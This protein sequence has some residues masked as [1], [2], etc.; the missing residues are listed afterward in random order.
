MVRAVTFSAQEKARGLSAYTTLLSNMPDLILASLFLNVLSLALP[1][2]LLQVYD[3][4]IPNKSEGT[5]QLLVL[6]V[7]TA[8]LFEA[9]LRLGRSTIT[10][11]VGAR[12]EHMAGCG[13]MA[14]MLGT[15]VGAFERD[16]SGAHLERFNALATVKDFYAGQAILTLLDLPFTAIYLF[17]VWFIA[18]ELVLIPGLLLGLFIL[19][20]LGVGRKLREALKRRMTADDRRFNFIIEVLS[21]I[22]TVKSMGMEAQ[23]LRRYERL[24]EGCAEGDYNVAQVSA[25]ALSL[26]SFFSQITTA[27]VAAYGSTLVLDHRLT[28]GGLAACT[29]L[30]GRSL[31]PVQKA[32]GIWTRFQ[33]IR[34]ARA[35]LNEIFKLPLEASAGLPKLPPIGGAVRMD[36][37]R[38]R[39]N[40][41]S[42][43]IMSGL[44]V[45]IAAGECIAIGGGNG[46]GKSTLLALMIGAVRPTEGRVLLDGY[47]LAEV[48]PASVKQQVAYLPQAGTLFQGSILENITMFRPELTELAYEAAGRLGLDDV[49]KTMALGYDTK[50][51]DGAFDA[52]PRGIKQRIA[53]ARA[54]VC[55]PRVVLFDEA[56]TGVDGVGDQYLKTCLEGLKG[57]CTMILVTHR[58]SLVKLADRVFDFKDGV[59][60]ERKQVTQAPAPPSA[61]PQPAPAS[62]AQ[63]AVQGGAA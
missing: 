32:L 57:Q 16:G 62:Q 58:P 54:L 27:A 8:L 60:T 21:G 24:Q 50:V 44:S 10:G 41:K 31:S 61:P 34:L 47:D 3:R 33:T 55:Q 42:P 26:A 15:S 38:F 39:F 52:L 29:M 59:L 23:M 1:V 19:T 40:E 13:A 9:I 5:L 2:A 30:A 49:V 11:W 28:V 46:S 36:G 63:P 6:G 35:R 20:A 4:I 37:V 56:N 17:L 22:H 7:G 12:F 51:G 45:E 14:R 18:S 53:V 43:E 25:S 48:D